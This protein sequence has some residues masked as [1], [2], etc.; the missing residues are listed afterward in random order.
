M[1]GSSTVT[2]FVKVTDP[3]PDAVN[4]QP[5]GPVVEAPAT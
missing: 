5:T 1:R 4:A 2:V 3:L